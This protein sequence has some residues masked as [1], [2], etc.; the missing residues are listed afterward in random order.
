ML[1]KLS[2]EHA[3]KVERL[4]LQQQQQVLEGFRTADK[5]C[6]ATT[7]PARVTRFHRVAGRAKNNSQIKLGWGCLG[8]ALPNSQKLPPRLVQRFRSGYYIEAS[9]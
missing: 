4:Q 7:L 2:A 6:R 1:I 5:D 3:E 9:A 8:T